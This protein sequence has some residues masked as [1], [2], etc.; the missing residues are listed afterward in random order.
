MSIRIPLIGAL[1][2]TTA[3]ANSCGEKKQPP[4]TTASSVTT[5]TTGDGGLKPPSRF[6]KPFQPGN[7]P[8]SLVDT[9]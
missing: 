5:G 2:F 8:T 4:T 6:A 1:L 9:D 7:V 3:C